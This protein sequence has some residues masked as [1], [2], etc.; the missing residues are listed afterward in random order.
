MA[1]ELRKVKREGRKKGGGKAPSLFPAGLNPIVDFLLHQCGRGV[2]KKG[3]KKE[4]KR[5][6]C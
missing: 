5:R 4:K 3:I 1:E 6:P 2:K